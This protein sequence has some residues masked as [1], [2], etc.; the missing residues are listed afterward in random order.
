MSNIFNIAEQQTLDIEA[1]HWVTKLDARR[2]NGDEFAQFKAWVSESK[3]HK[4]AFDNAVSLWGNLD[5]LS[6]M[7][8]AL[9]AASTPRWQDRLRLAVTSWI[10]RPAYAFTAA[11]L[12]LLVGLSLVPFYKPSAN[13]TAALYTTAVGEH[14]TISLADGSEVL[15]N[16]GSQL[17]V[18]FSQKRRT[19]RLLKGEAHFAVAHN[20]DRP[21]EVHAGA[22]IVRAVGTAFTVELMPENVEVTVTEGRVELATIAQADD[23]AHI[24]LETSLALVNSG[25]SAR[26]STAIQSINTI[27]DDEVARRLAWHKGALIFKGDALEDVIQEASRYTKTKMIIS[28]HALRGLKVGGYFKTGETKAMLQALEA[29]FGV[30]VKWVGTDLVYLSQSAAE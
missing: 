26:F 19:L 18:Q 14:K 20:A 12:V 28:D 21:F 4:D 1:T 24:P 3:D 16:T 29:N 11:T 13:N 30:S 2:L 15:L 22:N 27:N 25:Q 5:L 17:E 9:E 8:E 23:A 6:D 10:P 7:R